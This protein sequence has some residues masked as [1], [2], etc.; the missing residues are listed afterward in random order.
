MPA[1]C[2]LANQALETTEIAGAN[3]GS[4][5][6]GQTRHDHTSRPGRLPMEETVETGLL[7]TVVSDNVLICITFSICSYLLP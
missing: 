2:E 7:Q 4:P 6:L 5:T 1:T 3:L